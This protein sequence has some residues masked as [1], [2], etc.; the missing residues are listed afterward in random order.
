VTNRQAGWAS[1]WRAGTAEEVAHGAGTGRARGTV[2][3]R[4]SRTQ[5]RGG[6]LT[7]DLL[8]AGWRHGAANELARVTGRA[9]GKAV[10]GGADPNGGAVWRQWRSLGTAA[11]IGGVRAL[12]ANGDGGAAL[13]CRCER[14]KVWAASIGDNGGGWE[15]LTVKRQTRWRSEGN[16]RG[17]GVSGGGGW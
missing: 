10:G 9:P 15:G 14:G 12:V 2:T 13:Q 5:Q 7:S 1:A 8:V 17:G 6:V 4:S 3:A 16:Q 11:F